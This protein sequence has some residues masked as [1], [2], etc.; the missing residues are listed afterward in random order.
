[1]CVYIY[2]YICIYIYITESLCCTP[3]INTTLEINYT[4][5]K[6]LLFL[7]IDFIV[8]I[9]FTNIIINMISYL[10]RMRDQNAYVCEGI[11][12]LGSSGGGD[13]SFE[14]NI[15]PLLLY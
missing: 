14:N 4:L 7:F 15:C 11:I 12:P 3:E 10:Y 8:A 2:I 6:T 1:M 13:P 5:V 9:I